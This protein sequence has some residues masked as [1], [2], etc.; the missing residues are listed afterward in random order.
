MRKFSCLTWNIAKRI[1]YS[2]EQVNFINS[3][4]PDVVALQEVLISSD[5]KLKDLLSK[6]YKNIVSS[7]DLAPDLKILTK[8]R[9]FGQI[10]ASNFKLEP[11]DPK[12][13]NVPWQER[14]L[15]VK[16]FIDNFE[17]YFHTTHIP[18]GSGNGWIKIETLEGIYER[19]KENKINLNILCGDF[20]TPKEEDLKNGMVSFAQRIDDKGEAKVRKSFRGGEGVRWDKGERGIIV[21]LKEFGIEDS[22]RKLF[23]YDIKDYSWKFN[24]KDNVIKRR[25]DHFFASEKFK[26]LDANYLHNEKKLSDHSPLIVKYKIK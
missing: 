23:S 10:I 1:K 8:K 13:F 26:V 16:L 7:F 22:F 20:N 25:F 4:K 3:F 11:N 5:K 15:S 9:M 18:P 12:E 14:V 19:L 2:E 6:N 24:R 21:G 17:I